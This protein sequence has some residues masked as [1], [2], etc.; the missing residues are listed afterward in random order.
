MANVNYLWNV[1]LFLFKGTVMKTAFKAYSSDILE[2]CKQLNKNF[3]N[4]I[5]VLE[6][7]KFTKC[8]SNSIDYIVM[9]HIKKRN[10][11]SI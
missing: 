5:L 7:Y 6:E 4:N 2:Y 8:K 3:V 10:C 9:E 1:G 11:C